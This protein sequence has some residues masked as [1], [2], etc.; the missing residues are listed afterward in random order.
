MGFTF[1]LARGGAEGQV[2][3]KLHRHLRRVYRN[4]M[5][6]TGE[7]MVYPMRQSQ[8]T[9][10]KTIFLS[11]ITGYKSEHGFS[12]EKPRSPAW[13]LTFF[14]KALVEFHYV[15]WGKHPNPIFR[16]SKNYSLFST[17]RF[18]SSMTNVI[19]L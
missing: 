12:I 8:L 19:I 16:E 7:Y 9:S 2:E 15:E 6:I 13:V 5:S 14:D 18:S 11:V 1:D 17:L 4:E 10:L 3:G